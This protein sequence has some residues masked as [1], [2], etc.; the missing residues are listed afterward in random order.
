MPVGLCSTRHQIE[1]L[2]TKEPLRSHAYSILRNRR[3]PW[4]HFFRAS[5]RHIVD[6]RFIESV[7]TAVDDTYVIQ[8]RN[9]ADIAVSR[10]QSRQL[11][12]SLG[13]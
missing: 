6:L 10:R 3:W 11:R 5:R 9:R 8:L 2:V 13:L 12:E 7:E 4:R 1:P